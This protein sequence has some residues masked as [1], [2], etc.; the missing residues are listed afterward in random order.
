MLPATC[1]SIFMLT[2]QTPA[3]TLTPNFGTNVLRD[4]PGS[5]TKWHPALPKAE[6]A[7]NL[8]AV[9]NTIP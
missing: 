5:F 2:L 4:P 6:E 3:P 9:W 8:L 7:A 1:E